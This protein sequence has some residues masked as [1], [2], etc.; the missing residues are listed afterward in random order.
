M[1][2]IEHSKV[3]GFTTLI[4]SG[5]VRPQHIRG[6]FNKDCHFMVLGKLGTTITDLFDTN[7]RMFKKI[8]ILKLGI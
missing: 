1:L 5:S 4:D 8:D 6:L 7:T 3:D 2:N